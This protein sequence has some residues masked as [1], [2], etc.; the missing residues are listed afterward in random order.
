MKRGKAS[1][2]VLFLFLFLL[3]ISYSEEQYTDTSIFA[4]EWWNTS[5]SYRSQF[6][7][8]VSLGATPTNIQVPI[9]LNSSTIGDNFNWSRNCNDIRFTNESNNELSYWTDHCGTNNATVWLKI[10][11]NITTSAYTVYIYYGNNNVYN[12]SNGYTV[13]N[14]FDDFEDGNLTQGTVWTSLAGTWS[15]IKGE[16]Y[17]T[18]TGHPILQSNNYTGGNY[19][20]QARMRI[21]SSVSGDQQGWIGA[22]GNGSGNYYGYGYRGADGTSNWELWRVQGGGY[23]ELA[24]HTPHTMTQFRWFKN[25]LRVNSTTISG[26]SWIHGEQEPQSWGI[27]TS[28]TAHTGGNVTLKGNWDA[29]ELQ[30]DDIF[31]HK[32]LDSEIIINAASGSENVSATTAPAIDFSTITPPDSTST[33]L[34]SIKINFSVTESSLTQLIYHWNGTNYTL[35]NAS[36]QFLMNFD[37]RSELSENHTHANDISQFSRNGT[38]TGGA[39]WNSS[40]RYGGAYTFYGNGGIFTKQSFLSST[41]QF[42]MAGW[43]YAG[44]TGS[45]I[46]LWGQNDAVE[47]GFIDADSIM[48]WTANGGNIDWTIN[49]T[50]FPLNTWNHIATVANNISSPYLSL[51]IN[52]ILRASGGSAPGSTFGSS[53]YNFSIASGVFDPTG[54]NF[55]GSIDN[56]LVLNRSLSSSEIYQLYAS[57]LR[58]YNASQWELYV[59]QSGNSTNILTDG[60]YT[61]YASASNSQASNATPQHVIIIDTIAPSI[62][63]GATPVNNSIQNKN[64]TLINLS[65]DDRNREYSFIDSDKSLRLWLRFENLN[66]TGSPLDS[67]S[68]NTSVSNSS[69]NTTMFGLWGEAYD[70]SDQRYLTIPR[71]VQDDFT[72]CA[73]IKTTTVGNGKHWLSAPIIESEVAFADNDFGFGIGIGGL[74]VFG[75]GDGTI[76]RTI[77]ATKNVS[78]NQWH[79]LCGTRIKSN[80]TQVIYIDGIKNVSGPGGT[81]SLT[82]NAQ[83]MIGFGTDGA[84]YFNGTMDELII[85][86]RTLIAEEILSVYDSSADKYGQNFTG[87]QEG[88]HSFTAY[89]IDAAGNANST[90]I[91][92]IIDTIS[93]TW[94][95]NKTNLTSSSSGTVHFNITFNDSNAGYYI[96]SFYN[97]SGWINETNTYSV[98]SEINIL[99]NVTV[100]DINWTW[101]VNDSSSNTNQT[102]IWGITVIDPLDTDGD[103]ILD[104]SDPLLYNES[105][106]NISGVT[107]LNITIGG[108][109]TNG[110]FSGVQDILFYDGNSLMM[111]FSHNFSRSNLDLR[112]V[113]IIKAATS[114]IVNVSGLQGNKTLYI[115]DNSFISL[116]VKDAPINSISNI[117]TG[118]TGANETDFTACLGAGIRING[119]NCTDGGSTITFENL[120]H[121][122]IRGTQAGSGGGSDSG[123]S[124]GGGSSSRSASAAGGLTLECS[125]NNEC[126]SDRVCFLNKC[127]KLFD[128]KI[129]DV[130]P[131]PME[132]T[133]TKLEF[134]YF[135]KGMA[136]INGDVIVNFWLGKNDSIISEGQDV[137]YL[138]SFE[139]KTEKAIIYIPKNI[140]SGEYTFHVKVTYDNYNAVS[141]R[142]IYLEAGETPVVRFVEEQTPWYNMLISLGFT[143]IGLLLIICRKPLAQAGKSCLLTCVSYTQKLHMPHFGV[144]HVSMPNMHWNKP[145]KPISQRLISP[146]NNSELSE[147]KLTKGIL[148]AVLSPKPRYT[149]KKK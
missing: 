128:I 95:S 67:S 74:P 72:I 87:L 139:E 96:F 8:S 98:L 129:L 35:Y 49:S 117:T 13:F 108:N 76:D 38:I 68:Y 113:S 15:I 59:N 46:A 124:G 134:T 97:G 119:I 125:S 20:V 60:N 131:L 111:N 3:K 78:D 115:T 84:S 19:N 103:G 22:R 21:N 42:T 48:I 25:R 135:M 7:L 5:F 79:H 61:Y 23:S 126:P 107:S 99:K 89:A 55:T 14:F 147:D 69:I 26:K 116:C 57:N 56:I 18:S 132:K 83:A 62:S 121:S 4:A 50:I 32:F 90:F 24:Q 102:E 12:Q 106:V 93:P 63:F 148:E 54:G 91:T 1:V 85:W 37:N 81:T 66:G 141:F 118:C 133:Q 101:Y 145:M 100:G 6:N 10:P 80:G 75:N 86:N 105:N 31:V 65:T 30:F 146:E 138:G 41:A 110:S 58:K 140:S 137:I 144:P 47:F 114:L 44:S 112:N 29:A 77:N 51:Y 143:I 149:P 120:Q 71:P 122:A 34:T 92:V 27:F 136:N 40:G 64:Y 16:L 9:N 94:F 11:N 36:L 127:V 73:W 88:N 45:R 43:V 142:T 109:A 39:R 52:G 82:G 28:D 104:T 70:F 130:V 2:I 123:S 53:V 33:Q 17:T